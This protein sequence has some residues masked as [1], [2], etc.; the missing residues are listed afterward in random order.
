[1][2]LLFFILL[3]F[4]SN[5]YHLKICLTTCCNLVKWKFE[6]VLYQTGSGCPYQFPFFRRE[7][8][9][10]YTLYAKLH[11]ACTSSMAGSLGVYVLYGRISICVYPLWQDPQTRSLSN[12]FAGGSKFSRRRCLP[13]YF[14]PLYIPQPLRGLEITPSSNA[15]G[16]R[17]MPASCIEV[18]RPA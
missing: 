11:S 14:R 12:R 7:V 13:V 16:A 5:L 6:S 2:L 17:C 9:G 15:I 3:F 10:V 18:Q 4:Y 1:M 8:L